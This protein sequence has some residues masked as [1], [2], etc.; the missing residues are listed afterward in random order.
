MISLFELK[1]K[2]IGPKG[3]PNEKSVSEAVMLYDIIKT[4]Y[5]MKTECSASRI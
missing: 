1:E 2:Y 3:D 5:T 4:E